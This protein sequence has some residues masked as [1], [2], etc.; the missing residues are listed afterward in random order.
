MNA[1]EIFKKN[2]EKNK[3]LAFGDKVLVAVSGGPDSTALLHLLWRFRK[4]FPITLKVVH[5]D[6]GLRSSSR[7]E[8]KF[9]AKLSKKLGIPSLIRNIPVKKAAEIHKVSLETAGRNLRYGALEEIARKSGFNKIATGH[10]AD[11]NAE[12]VVMWILRGAGT[13]GL[14]GIPIKR[15]L[16]DGLSVI[17]PILP[18]SKEIIIS[19]LKGQKIGFCIDESNYKF[20][21]TRNKIRHKVISELKELNNKFVEHVFTLSKI[22]AGESAFFEN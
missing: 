22:A 15:K 21:F 17:R 4:T 18:I 2:I 12:T 19:Y 3:L 5:L 14:A 1:W 6:H 20:D 8:A 10:T 9:V 7:K 11:D 16:S 13:E